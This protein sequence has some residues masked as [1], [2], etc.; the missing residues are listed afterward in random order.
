VTG[1]SGEEIAWSAPGDR[2]FT[3]ACGASS[4]GLIV[5][6]KI[7]DGYPLIGEAVKGG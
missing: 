3:A 2:P 7:P 4:A 6:T 1:V 5:A